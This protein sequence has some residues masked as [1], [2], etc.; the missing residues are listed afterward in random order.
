MNFLQRIR[1]FFTARFAAG[2]RA[3]Q[4]FKKL[5]KEGGYVIEE[6]SQDKESYEQYAV[7]TDYAKRG[8]Y[9]FV[10]TN[11]EVDVKCLTK[12]GRRGYQCLSWDQ[13]KRHKKMESFANRQVIFAIFERRGRRVIEESLRMVPL[14]EL[15]E[16]RKRKP[17][18][19]YDEEKRI[20]KIP[21]D[22]MY[23]GFELLKKLE[24]QRKQ[25][26]SSVPEKSRA[27]DISL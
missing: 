10:K 5:C 18:V 14:E 11:V 16:V 6:I 2:E 7:A 20:L 19:F 8:D 26:I 13:I 4:I 21:V 23:P 9:L 3:E 22:T 24:A 12:Y 1:C 17:G 27:H 15:L 25:A